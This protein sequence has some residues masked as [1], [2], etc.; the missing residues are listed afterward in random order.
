MVGRP[1]S[2]R[3]QIRWMPPEPSSPAP[4]LAL[5]LARLLARDLA[6]QHHAERVKTN[7]T[8]PRRQGE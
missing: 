1:V 3:L 8:K 7:E 5:T 4:H 6:R 2:R